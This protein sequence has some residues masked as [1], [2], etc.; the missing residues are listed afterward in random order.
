M[1]G[2]TTGPTFEVWVHTMETALHD[3]SGYPSNVHRHGG[4]TSIS[5]QERFLVLK[6]DRGHTQNYFLR[7][8]VS[9]GSRLERR[10]G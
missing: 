4:V 9:Y 3:G 8:L 2:P 5:L 1:S 7:N 10:T 6:T